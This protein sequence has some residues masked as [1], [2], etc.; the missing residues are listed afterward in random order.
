MAN[1]I[2]GTGQGFDAPSAGRLGGFSFIP[3]HNPPESSLRAAAAKV[4]AAVQRAAP[5]L[6]CS[7]A[8]RSAVRS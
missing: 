2:S 5:V 1:G 8:V 7:V 6:G 3:H 4:G